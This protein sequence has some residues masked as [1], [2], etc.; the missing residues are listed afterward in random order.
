[1]LCNFYLTCYNLFEEVV[2]QLGKIN[3]VSYR[4]FVF[5]LP[6]NLTVMFVCMCVYIYNILCK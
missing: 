6:I 3:I 5:I 1:M 4:N 2:W